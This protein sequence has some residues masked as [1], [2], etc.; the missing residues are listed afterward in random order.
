MP[1]KWEV[2]VTPDFWVIYYASCEID[3]KIYEWKV[4]LPED[5]LPNRAIPEQVRTWG[6]IAF[7]RT[8]KRLVEEANES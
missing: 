7:K 4:R 2:I 3:G 5:P 1:L 8:R 6:E